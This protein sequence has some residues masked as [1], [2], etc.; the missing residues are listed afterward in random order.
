[1]FIQKLTLKNFRCFNEKTFDFGN[2]IIVIEGRNGIGKSSLIEAL[3]YSCYLKSF[4]THLHRDIINLN[5]EFFFVSVDFRLEETGLFD[6]INVGYSQAEGKLVKYN[7]K[8]IQSYKELV[9]RYRIVALSADDLQLIQG[10][11]ELRRAF[12]NYALFLQKPETLLQYKRFKSVLDQR[13]KLLNESAADIF[14]SDEITLWTEQLWQITVEIQEIRR[15][16]LICLQ[17]RVNELLRAY[18]SSS[19]CELQVEFEYLTKNM[20]TEKEFTNFWANYQTKLLNDEL[21]FRRSLFG[22]HLDDFLITFQDKRARAFASRG[23]QKLIVFLIKLAQLQ[24]TC[25]ELGVL[26]LDDFVTDFDQEKLAGC[27]N[28]LK[29]SPYQIFL[30]CPEGALSV[31]EGLI[32]EPFDVIKLC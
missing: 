23:Q 2:R 3:H 20:G 21:A 4:R 13:N 24:E 17:D 30:T 12:L 29:S 11:P 6:Q 31:L 5:Q 10:A 16:Y 14:A 15:K 19:S 32:K 18:F 22:L 26:L 27:F 7:Q 25:G 9:S 8:P 28:I 1:V